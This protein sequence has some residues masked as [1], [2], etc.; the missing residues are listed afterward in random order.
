M[1][2]ITFVQNVAYAATDTASFIT[3]ITSSLLTDL[4]ASLTAVAPVVGVILGVILA[5]KLL[6]R[7]LGR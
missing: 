7:F 5:W 1:T 2:M 6:K 4:W 3:E